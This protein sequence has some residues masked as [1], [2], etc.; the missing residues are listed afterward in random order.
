MRKDKKRAELKHH[1][2]GIIYHADTWWLITS[3]IYSFSLT[4]NA[5]ASWTGVYAH[6]FVYPLRSR[7][8]NYQSYN[9]M[10]CTFIKQY[11]LQM[12]PGKTTQEKV[13]VIMRYKFKGAR[14][15]KDKQAFISR[16]QGPVCKYVTLNS[17]RR[18]LT[19]K[20]LEVRRKGVSASD[21]FSHQNLGINCEWWNNFQGLFMFS[22]SFFCNINGYGNFSW[23][24]VCNNTQTIAFKH[25]QARLPRCHMH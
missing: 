11:L 25:H 23:M 17:G 21:I 14:N 6:N 16:L 8:S 18:S 22:C 9:K 7:A 2:V 5:L 15:C 3:R 4:C 12:L 10:C 24:H 19:E 1:H 20:M 13:F